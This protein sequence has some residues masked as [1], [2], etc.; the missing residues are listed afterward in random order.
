MLMY[1]NDLAAIYVEEDLGDCCVSD[2][3][4]MQYVDENIHGG[5]DDVLGVEVLT[6]SLSLLVENILVSDM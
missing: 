3:W 2:A 5:C 6:W 1:V 4:P